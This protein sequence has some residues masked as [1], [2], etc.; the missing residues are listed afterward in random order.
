ME[1]LLIFTS[2]TVFMLMFKIGINRSPSELLSLWQH[3]GRVAGSLLAVLVM[4]PA[5]FLAVVWLFALPTEAAVALALLAA[6]PGAP[7]TTKRSEIAAADPE[8]VSSL[9]LSLTR[10]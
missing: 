9:Q 4:V 1:P 5:V 6:A 2:I 7:L 10:S 8:Y 3:P